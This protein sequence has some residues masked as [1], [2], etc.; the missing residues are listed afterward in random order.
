MMHIWPPHRGHIKVLLILPL[1][2]FLVLTFADSNTT[3]EPD[4]AKQKDAENALITQGDAKYNT[5]AKDQKKAE[6]EKKKKELAKKAQEEAKKIE[7]SIKELKKKY[8]ETD[9][10]EMKKK[11]KQKLSQLKEE[12]K[13]KKK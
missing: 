8:K 1:F 5:Q 11:I 3:R 4:K 10:P 9:D 12:L 7:I 6:D 2:S 13:K